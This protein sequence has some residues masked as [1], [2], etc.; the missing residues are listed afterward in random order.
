MRVH[1]APVHDLPSVTGEKISNSDITKIFTESGNSS[2][3][4]CYYQTYRAAEAAAVRRV[5]NLIKHSEDES[6][7]T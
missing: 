3:Y 7:E 1:Y 6:N 4:Y 5:E 2:K